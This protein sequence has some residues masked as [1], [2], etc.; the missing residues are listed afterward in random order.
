[1]GS[2]LQIPTSVNYCVHIYYFTTSRVI[3]VISGN[4]PQKNESKIKSTTSTTIKTN[5]GSNFRCMKFA[6][7]SPAFSKATRNTRPTAIT[8]EVKYPT[9][10]LTPISKTRDKNTFP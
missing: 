3:N 4:T 2:G 7:T 8:G 1:M 10:K 5:T 9:T 6:T